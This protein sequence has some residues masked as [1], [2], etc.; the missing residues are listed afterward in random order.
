MTATST[1]D[2]T[3]F[4]DRQ[5]AAEGKSS[6]V[7]HERFLVTG[8]SGPPCE[9][10]PSQWQNGKSST[11]CSQRDQ[12]PFI[13]NN[14]AIV[15]HQIM[16]VITFKQVGV[17]DL[18]GLWISVKS[19]RNRLRFLCRQIPIS[20]LLLFQYEAL[21]LMWPCGTYI[22]LITAHLNRL[23]FGWSTFAGSGS[24]NRNVGLRFCLQQEPVCNTFPF[25]GV[26]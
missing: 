11:V 17:R 9:V 22:S 4:Q 13:L 10:L 25:T 1:G 26:I 20:L 24:M 16:S 7:N 19:G 12:S 21:L 23:L 15:Q 3:T 2:I 18:D 8:R 14:G 5:T 6:S